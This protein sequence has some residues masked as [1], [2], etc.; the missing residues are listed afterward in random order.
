MPGI[1]DLDR[2]LLEKGIAYSSLMAE[3]LVQKYG[4]PGLIISSSAI[5]ALHT[6]IVMSRT[7]NLNTTLIQ[8]NEKVY[9][10]KATR[11]IEIIDEVPSKIDHLMLVGHN[12]TLTDFVN[13]FLPEKIDNL[14][15]SGIVTIQFDSKDWDIAHLTPKSTD[16]DFPKKE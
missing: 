7:M 3:R 1:S 9:E 2:P 11:I 15:T 4:K 5:R 6:A 16:V 12:P 10:C 8:I 14:P 13:F